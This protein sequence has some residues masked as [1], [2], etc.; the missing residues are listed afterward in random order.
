MKLRIYPNEL[1]PTKFSEKQYECLLKD[2]MNIREEYPEAR[3]YKDSIC[4]QNDVTPKTKEEAL[5][6]LH[7]DGDYF[8]LCHAGDPLTIFLTVVTVLSAALAIYT[9]MNMPEI[10][11]QASGSGNNSLAS[12]QNKH[13]TSERVPD[14]YGNVKS[15]P[16]LIAPVYRYYA[17]NVQVEETLMSIGTGYFEIE[18]DQI[19]EG[20]TPVNTIEGASLSAY[21][22]GTLITGTPQIQ[23]GEEFTVPPIVA[24][25]VSS[26]D[27]KQKLLS[28]NNTKLNYKG[29]TFAGNK[30][31][32]TGDYQY[33]EKDYMYVGGAFGWSTIPRPVYAN[34]SDHFV[35]GEQVVIENAI[36]GSAPDSN[37]SGTTNV[38]TTGI[39]TIAS[40]I[41]IVDPDNYKKIRI[42]SL[43]VEDLVEGQLS[44][45]GEYAV[46][47]IV[48]TG[49]AGAWFYEV[50]LKSNYTEANIN[51]G[52]M[53]DDG[54]GILSAVLT[55]HDENIDLSGTYT[56]SSVSTNEITLVNPSAVNPD[57]LLLPNLTAQQISNMLG[58][59]ITFKGTSENFIGW[60]YAGNKDTEGMMLNFLAANGIYE[61]DKAKQVAIEVHYQQV[62]DGVPTGQI[63]KTGLVMQGKANNRDQVGASVREKLPF[64][65]QFRFRAKRI[66]DNGSNANL[67]DDVVFE[68]AYSFYETKKTAYEYDTTIRLKRLAIGS[69]TNASELNL[70]VTRKLYSYRDGTRSAE[71]IPTSNFADIIINMALDPFIGRF[72]ISEIDVQS[73]Y[74]VSD[75]IEAYF[76]TPKACEFNYTFDNKNSSYQEMA[77]AVAEAVFC[78]ARRENGKH[79]FT[80]EKETPNSLILFNHRNIKPESLTKTNL[81]GVPDEYEGIEFKWRDETDDYAEAVIK[82]PHDGLAN[83]KTIESNGVT[84]A[85][86]AHF[87]AHRAWNKMQFNRKTIEFTAYGE[88]DLVTRND[89]IA[90]VDDVFNMIGSGEVEA[91]N[92][93]VLTLDNSINLQAGESYVIHLQLKDG[94]VDVINIVSQLDE[95]QVELARIPLMPLVIDKVV[96]ATYSITKASDQESEA[97][98]IQ[99]KSP[100][101]TFETSVSAIK[102]DARYYS[103]DKDYIKNLI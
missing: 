69:G 21:E 99:E 89:R 11:D 67:I 101:A 98:L 51:F 19:K 94:S 32:V 87:L 39:L 2:W 59:S 61:G 46:S 47:N 75:E 20:E 22:P 10:P 6:L 38:S 88:A 29:V 96:N 93:T 53:S 5:Q 97:Y 100:S 49:S 83:Y 15:I 95:N 58:R 34:F 40:S 82:L 84:N 77:F 12:R 64:T 54:T 91:Q 81:F 48:K 28:P 76:G 24:K 66:N 26:V 37:I 18:Q 43:T 80:F 42:S 1:D 71:R 7:A 13:R 23:I 102:Y 86:Q 52:R 27:G 56:I 63:Y 72:D 73:L 55:D 33:I 78:T 9:Y 25:Q 31:E 3:L 90:V 65:G 79:F 62:V 41:D 85:I 4:A 17:D 60:Y 45:A 68:S 30:I 35:N 36:Y 70:P 16:D 14:I 50:T 103:N 8:V 92:N 74:E 57:W 44:L